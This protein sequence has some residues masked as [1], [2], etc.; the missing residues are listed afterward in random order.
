[1]NNIEISN[2]FSNIGEFLQIRGD[3]SFR[4]RSYERAAR[5]IA[6]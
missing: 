1:M 2:I 3:A 6:I 4:I 5:V